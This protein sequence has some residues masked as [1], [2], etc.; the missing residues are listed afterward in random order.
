ME[1]R[2]G[3][4][5]Q[6]L[7]G[8]GFDPA[9]I[10]GL[11]APVSGE[12]E[13]VRRDEAEK[14]AEEPSTADDTAAEVAA[15]AEVA[16][17][18]V[19]ADAGDADEADDEAPVDG[20]V[21]EA[22][23]RRAKIVADHKGVRLSL[24][25]QACE[26]RWDEV[27]A[28]ETETGRFGKRF[29]VTVHTPDR[30]W[31]PI[32]IEA[33]SR[34]RFAEWESALDEVLDAYFDDGEPEAATEPESESEPDAKS[35]DAETD[36]DDAKDADAKDADEKADEKAGKADGKAEEKADE[37]AGKKTDEDATARAE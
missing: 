19:E 16:V 34:S 22:S 26:F 33:S 30:R 20:P 29:T 31:Y 24:D 12:P 11:T 10:P 28:V 2:R 23:D 9:F 21:F 27:G 4:T 3:S 5:S 35:D 37:K 32:E 7:E 18:A 15:E 13:D 8:A 14:D 17:D 36:A 6:P 1:Q 25:D